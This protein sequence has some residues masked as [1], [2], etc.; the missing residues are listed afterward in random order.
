MDMMYTPSEW[1]Q[2][3]H[4]LAGGPK[5]IHEALG[6][7][8]AGPGKSMVLLMDPTDQIILEHD[9]CVDKEHPYYR[10]WG[11]STGWAL[12]LRRTRPMLCDWLDEV[13]P[14]LETRE[15][16]PRLYSMRP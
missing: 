15:R 11:M 3:F 12:H 16:G 4:D 5:G 13:Q 8:A 14:Q 10:P 9:R 7:G 6:A 2:R 1:G